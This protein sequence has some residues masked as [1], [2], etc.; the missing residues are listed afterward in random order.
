MLLIPECAAAPAFPSTYIAVK[1][2]PA[3]ALVHAALL[4]V[5][6]LGIFEHNTKMLNRSKLP[7]NCIDQHFRNKTIQ[8]TVGIVYAD[9]SPRRSSS[10][11]TGLGGDKLTLSVARIRRRLGSALGVA[12]I[13]QRQTSVCPTPTASPLP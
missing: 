10:A 12:R 6:S 8:T 9:G 1:L 5:S 11:K 4:P 2:S 13:R 3:P 7:V